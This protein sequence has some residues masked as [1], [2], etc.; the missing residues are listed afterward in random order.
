MRY[1]LDERQDQGEVDIMQPDQI[2]GEVAKWAMFALIL[3]PLVWAAL[4]WW[5]RR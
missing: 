5:V 2:A 1:T 3:F 4:L